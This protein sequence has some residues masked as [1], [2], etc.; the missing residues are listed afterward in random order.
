LV[1]REGQDDIGTV[2]FA[3]AAQIRQTAS[4]RKKLELHTPSKNTTNVLQNIG[5]DDLRE[6]HV[7]PEPVSKKGIFA[8]L[9]HLGMT[10]AFT[11]GEKDMDD[12]KNELEDQYEFVD[13]FEL[14]IPCRV[15]MREVPSNRSR[16][17]LDMREWPDESGVA[18]AHRAGIRGA[19]TLVGVLDTG[20][21]ADHQEF[22][23]QRINYRYVSLQPNSPYWPPRDVRGFDTDGHGTHVCG[24]IAGKNIGVAPEAQLYA[25]SVIESETIFTSLTRVA[26]GLNWLFRQFT[27]PDNEHLPAVLSMSLGFP[28]NLPGVSDTQY[29]TRLKV[30]RTLLKTLVQANVLPIVAI[31]NEGKG[32]YGYPGAF[33]EVLG[34]GAVDFNGKVASFSGSGKPTGEGVSKPDLVGYGVGVNSALERDYGGQPIYQRLNGTSMATPYVAG[35][36]SLY[37][38]LYPA[39]TVQEIK[40]MLLDNALS[41]KPLDRV[42]VGLARFPE[43][44]WESINAKRKKT[45]DQKGGTRKKRSPPKAAR[46]GSRKGT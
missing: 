36:A 8:P 38:S 35:I 16:T 23:S 22:T 31:G 43:G 46:Q 4:F 28:E 27:R 1:P 39:L 14:S 3:P 42:G 32:N 24:I 19:G 11:Q 45:T 21:D 40:A 18:M 41:L 5:F 20:I 10:A 29:Q 6:L 13:D 44:I 2:T 9:D 7:F 15:I 25:A 17:A 30:M 12:A 34:V 33:K 37:R 26:A